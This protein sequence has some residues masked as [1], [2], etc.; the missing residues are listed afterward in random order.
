[1]CVWC[2]WCTFVI[3]LSLHSLWQIS[4]A[5]SSMADRGESVSDGGVGLRLASGGGR[6][7]LLLALAVHQVDQFV[8][9]GA[10]YSVMWHVYSCRSRPLLTACHEEVVNFWLL[11]TRKPEVMSLP[12][13]ALTA[14]RA[15]LDI[16]AWLWAATIN[17]LGYCLMVSRWPY[18]P[19]LS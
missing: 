17:V 14:W 6:R 5:R 19:F 7:L 11:A 1:M 8:L 10:R 15:Q 9:L 13:T 18:V 12:L 3:A 4:L 2:M 16:I